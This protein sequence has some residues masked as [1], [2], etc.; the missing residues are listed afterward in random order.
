ML[1]NAGNLLRIGYL[2]A[3][4]I[5]VVCI[6][7]QPTYPQE[8]VDKIVATVSDG[9]SDPEL[10]T[11]TD[12]LW[13]LALEPDTPLD[14]PTSD[15]LNRAL[16][17]LVNLRLF[18]LEAQRL[19][20]E[21]PKRE[22]IEEEIKRIVANFRSSDEFKNR[23]QLVGFQSK[24]DDNFQR[25]MKQ[26]VAIEK[27]IEFRFRSFVIITQEDELKYFREVFT[28]DFRRKNPGLLLPQFEDEKL[29]INEILTQQKIAQDIETFLDDAT[30]RAE[31]V[32]LSKV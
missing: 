28:P 18:A 10:I 31:I 25:M 29:K 8:I 23:L 11:Y 5:T 30:R 13:Q 4:L 26:R 22:Q 17:T 16:Q 20:S 7:F 9:A 19:P 32:Y 6:S 3:V 2:G 12:L 15:D 21:E 14:P 1:R 24:D 27:Y